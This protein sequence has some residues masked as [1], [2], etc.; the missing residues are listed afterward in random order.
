MTMWNNPELRIAGQPAV[1]AVSTARALAQ[2]HQLLLEGSLVSQRLFEVF[3]FIHW[4][5][6]VFLIL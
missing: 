6:F 4:I 5:I 2:T 3:I 1:N